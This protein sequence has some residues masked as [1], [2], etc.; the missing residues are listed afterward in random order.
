MV[1]LILRWLNCGVVYFSY[2]IDLIRNV[3]EG[4]QTFFREDYMID[5]DLLSQLTSSSITNNP[6]LGGEV[7]GVR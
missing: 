1:G 4:T 7:V 3:V 6:T 2:Y 5:V